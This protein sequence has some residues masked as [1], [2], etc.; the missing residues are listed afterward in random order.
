MIFLHKKWLKYWKNR[1]KITSCC[2]DALFSNY[3]MTIE[4]YGTYCC[5]DSEMWY[6]LSISGTIVRNILKPSWVH[7]ILFLQEG[8]KKCKH[9]PLA[10]FVIWSAQHY[11]L[12]QGPISFW[13]HKIQIQITNAMVFSPGSC[14]AIWSR[15][16]Y[17]IKGF[18]PFIYPSLAKLILNH[19]QPTSA[20]N[21]VGETCHK[22]ENEAN[23]I[24]RQAHH[25]HHTQLFKC[26][27][28]IELQSDFLC[29]TVCVCVK[30]E[31]VFYAHTTHPFWGGVRRHPINTMN[32]SDTNCVAWAL[33]IKR[34]LNV[35]AKAITE[36]SPKQ[37][38]AWLESAVTAT[39]IKPNE[40]GTY[41]LAICLRSMCVC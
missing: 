37:C 3:I 41:F 18:W 12:Q 25:H 17:I 11:H 10:F 40:I 9:S 16:L 8:E 29:T 13:R 38:R 20:L 36:P 6:P 39:F 31:V 33:Y 30:R 23:N 35:D 15:T 1:P 27:A 34:V 21:N 14:P 7:I 28:R 19:P 22:Y 26:I 4:K 5:W 24:L 32:N 2:I